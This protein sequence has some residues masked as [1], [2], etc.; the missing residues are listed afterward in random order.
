MSH[1]L[2]SRLCYKQHNNELF[3]QQ[4]CDIK[5]TISNSSS[6]KTVFK[7]HNISLSLH[8]C[9]EQHNISLFLRQDPLYTTKKTTNKIWSFLKFQTNSFDVV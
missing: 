8:L 4:D 6:V 9:Y 1:Y 2:S 7:Q 3:L 5:T